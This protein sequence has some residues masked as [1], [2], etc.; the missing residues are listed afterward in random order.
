MKG[1]ER[2]C[3]PNLYK[4]SERCQKTTWFASTWTV[5]VPFWRAFSIWDDSN[6]DYGA[7]GL[8]HDYG[9]SSNRIPSTSNKPDKDASLDCKQVNAYSSPMR[10]VY[11]VALDSVCLHS[12]LRKISLVA[13]I[14]YSNFLKLAW[15]H[16]LAHADMVVSLKISGTPLFMQN[17]CLFHGFC[18]WNHCMGK[19]HWKPITR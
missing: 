8:I 4:V 14:T 1:Y 2:W 10:G 13:K 11:G 15:N 18:F 12:Y 19:I 7:C 9:F 17:Q 6:P 3:L 16:H 5:N